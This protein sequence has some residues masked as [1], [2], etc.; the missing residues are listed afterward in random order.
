[1]TTTETKA[2]E[3]RTSRPP[4]STVL[5]FLAVA[6]FLGTLALWW[7][8][9]LPGEPEFEVGR[10]VFGNIP[11]VV[12]TLFYVLVAAFT[13][14]AI[15]LFA[16]R[17]ANWER[18]TWERRSGLWK[19]RLRRFLDGVSMRTVAEDPASGVMHSLIYWGFVILFLGT[20]TL[21]ID[22]LLPVDLKF[23]QGTVYQGYSL[24]LD[25]AAVAFL[26]GILWAAVR[27]YGVKPW[28]IRS[29]SRPE[30]AWILI[31]LGTI[32]VTGLLT[33]AAR[34]SLVGR[35]D[36][37]VWSVV[38]YPL[39][40]LVAAIECVR[41]PPDHVDCP[42]CRFLRVSRLPPRDEAAAHV[43]DAGEPRS[44][45]EGASKGCDEGDAEPDGGYGY[46]VRRS[47]CRR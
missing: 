38:G 14:V 5:W 19:R 8:G 45:G 13:A 39:S 23:L 37:E 18:G 4:I 31:L 34:I 30:D 20:V 44:F 17:A 24:I 16:L 15:G 21:E 12:V 29:K 1:M 32:G 6:S 46:R 42:R 7:L 2:E 33:E 43:H 47:R 27:R 11:D 3:R 26:A 28:R 9:E 40:S 35:P 22:H 10:E 25:L 36:F 41:I